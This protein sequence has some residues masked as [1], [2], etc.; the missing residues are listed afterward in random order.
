MAEA[1]TSGSTIYPDRDYNF[2]KNNFKTLQLVFQFE[3]PDNISA[4]TEITSSDTHNSEP[5]Y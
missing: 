1:K 2:H 4:L 5:A 3:A